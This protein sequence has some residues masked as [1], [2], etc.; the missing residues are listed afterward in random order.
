[1]PEG[2]AYLQAEH[3]RYGLS[4]CVESLPGQSH[5]IAWIKRREFW[6]QIDDD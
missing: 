6:V 5:Y 2:E 4:S 3:Q 1:M